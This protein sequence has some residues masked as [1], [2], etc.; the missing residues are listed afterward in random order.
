[1][2]FHYRNL[3]GANPARRTQAK[4]FASA[5][6]LSTIKT[7]PGS[8]LVDVAVNAAQAPVLS[9]T[10]ICIAATA[11]AYTA[12]TASGVGDYGAGYAR[13]FLR[14]NLQFPR[15]FPQGFAS[16]VFWEVFC[17]VTDCGSQEYANNC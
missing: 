10:F 7:V 5:P 8:M 15:C 4:E 6:P 1:M 17:F 14:C 11:G 13:P 3:V 9:A 16:G 2:G 12:D